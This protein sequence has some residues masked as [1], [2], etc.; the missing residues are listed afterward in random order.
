MKDFT[1]SVA[2]ERARSESGWNGEPPVRPSDVADG[3]NISIQPT[4]LDS[5]TAAVLVFE[6]E[7]PKAYLNS[8]L[9]PKEVRPLIARV[10]GHFLYAAKHHFTVED[11]GR[12][13]SVEGGIIVDEPTDVEPGELDWCR[14]FTEELLVP[15]DS[16][17]E[18]LRYFNPDRWDDLAYLKERFGVDE[19]LLASRIKIVCARAAQVATGR[20]AKR[21]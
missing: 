7:M 4:T 13:Y 11:Y 21:G 2:A 9:A 19:T 17:E 5:A 1:P 20:H 14:E 15:L 16:L 6:D 3:L 10:I 12:I 8:R 18:E